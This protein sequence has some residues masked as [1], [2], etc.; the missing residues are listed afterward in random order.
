[1]G[2]G[3]SLD[4]FSVISFVLEVP[5]SCIVSKR[6]GR[7]LGTWASVR[8]LEHDD[9]KHFAGEQTT[10]LG[11]PLVNELLIGTTYKNEWNARHPSG[12]E[13][14]NEFLLFPAVPAI[15][16]LLFGSNGT[17]AVAHADAPNFPRT[18]L[19][20]VLHTGIPNFNQPENTADD[21]DDDDDHK[22][23]VFADLLR[24]N[25]DVATF[26]NCTD[27]SALS[28]LSAVA[29]DFAG[30]PNG[31]RLGDDI[32]D[33]V[34]R[35]AEGI[36][37]AGGDTLGI[38]NGGRTTGATATIVFSDNVP[39]D[40]C[41]FQC[42]TDDFPFLNPPIPGDQLWKVTTGDPYKN[43]QWHDRGSLALGHCATAPL[44]DKP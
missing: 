2:D 28:V 18:D 31:R 13:R 16:Q 30:F 11:N 37:C 40:A 29:P 32:V 33:I 7:I 19:I 36:L 43:S 39:I 5:Q 12:D 27:Q 44:P 1:V 8:K 25:L 9:G 15:A 35:V 23:P 6:N 42:G 17:F 24:I 21:N 26:K 22:K 4:R 3:N 41:Q 38:C 34:L 20:A 10:R 14:F